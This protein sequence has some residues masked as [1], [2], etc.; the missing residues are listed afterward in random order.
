V[1]G[2][3]VILDAET[4]EQRSLHHRPLAYHRHVSACLRI[5]ESG[6]RA[7]LKQDFFNGIRAQASRPN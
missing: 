3:H 7:D 4:V 5:P 1:I 2:W 6:L